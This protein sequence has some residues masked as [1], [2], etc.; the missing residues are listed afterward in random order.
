MIERFKIFVSVVIVWKLLFS[1]MM[2]K[3]KNW[4][5]VCFFMFGIGCEYWENYFFVDKVNF[6]IFWN[7]DCRLVSFVLR[8][9]W[10]VVI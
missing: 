7:C 5:I 4:Y 1:I 2:V 8:L 9:N 3:I 6:L 10:L